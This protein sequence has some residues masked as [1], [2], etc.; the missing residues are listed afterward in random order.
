[1]CVCER[2]GCVVV[3]AISNRLHLKA[4]TLLV[5]QHKYSL[6]GIL[7]TKSNKLSGQVCSMPAEHLLRSVA[8]SKKFAK[9]KCLCVW[10]GAHALAEPRDR[11]AQCNQTA[12]PLASPGSPPSL[13][14]DTAGHFTAKSDSCTAITISTNL[15]AHT[16]LSPN[17]PPVSSHSPRTYLPLAHFYLISIL[18]LSLLYFPSQ[19]PASAAITLQT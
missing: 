10:P 4:L 12:V 17:L 2:L 9:V 6:Q 14:R 1:M 8:P 16:S 5:C 19:L 3:T 18:S 7:T 11:T 15:P 13:L